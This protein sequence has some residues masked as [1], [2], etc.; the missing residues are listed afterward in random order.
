MRLVFTPDDNEIIDK[1]YELAGFENKSEY[2]SIAL[3]MNKATPFFD[4]KNNQMDKK[5][6]KQ[7]SA[8]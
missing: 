6:A 4:H 8:P 3:T 5:N 2:N 7:N 1:I